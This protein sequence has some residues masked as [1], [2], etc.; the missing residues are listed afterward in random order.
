MSM[1]FV[2]N[3]LIQSIRECPHNSPEENMKAHIGC[4]Y[5]I[6]SNAIITSYVILSI[7]IPAGQLPVVYLNVY[8]GVL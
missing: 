5:D 6:S 4:S 2:Q 1:S 7:I 8:G 3:F